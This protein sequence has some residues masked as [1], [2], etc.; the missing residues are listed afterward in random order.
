MAYYFWRGVDTSGNSVEGALTCQNIREGK[1]KLNRKDIFQ[2][3]FERV[4]QYKIQTSL[5]DEILV[6]FLTNL[7]RLLKSGME[8]YD[9]LGF[10]IR[11][12]NNT[13]FC[14]LL[15]S[16]REDLQEGKSFSMAIQKY[17]CFPD[18]F[19]HLMRAGEEVGQ[20]QQVI[21]V[22]LDYFGFQT[23]MVNERK[24][25]MR[26]PLTVICIAGVLFL[27]LLVFVIPMFK[28]IFVILGDDLLWITKVMISLSES[29][30][31]SP[32]YWFIGAIFVGLGVKYMNKT[33]GSWFLYCLP[34]GRSIEG[35]IRVLSYSKS[36]SVMLKSG[37]GL[38]EALEL[39]E[40]LFPKRIRLK[41]Q[42]IHQHIYSGETL[43]NAYT[44]SSLFPPVFIHL[45]A[46]GES[47]GYLA[48]SFDRIASIY[49]DDLEKRMAT[50]N[51]M[52]EP[53]F[54]TIISIGVLVVLLSIYLPI[55]SLAE[56]F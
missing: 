8:L 29:L 16:I 1:I 4:A 27:G 55:F 28:R 35:N 43:R 32:E 7:D 15:S 33:V 40:S 21:Q 22:L 13:L 56:H 49:Q 37:L 20:F 3:K 54:M 38:R 9:C 19:V 30:R 47:S 25:I 53:I 46:L 10:I 48:S 17:R 6:E 34:G 31:Y 26:Y 41:V 51:A 36:L 18:I 14:Y 42:G 50:L 45:V 5:S 23:K 11:Y 2:L 44:T 12:H 52:I 39:T 24:K